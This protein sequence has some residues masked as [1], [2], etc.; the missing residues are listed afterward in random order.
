MLKFAA[1]CLVSLT[2][3]STAVAQ[4]EQ[5]TYRDA[6]VMYRVVS[7]QTVRARRVVFRSVTSEMKAALW[8]VHV[9]HFLD[10]HLELSLVQRNVV[11]QFLTLI[12]AELYQPRPD[13]PEWEA[14][15]G[16]PFARMEQSASA[17]LSPELYREAFA[18][19]GPLPDP[20]SDSDAQIVSTAAMLRRS[21]STLQP[22]YC[23]GCYAPDCECN[24]GDNWCF[25]GQS[26]FGDNCKSDSWGCGTVWQKICNGMCR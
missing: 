15:I 8:R 24:L 26:C 13:D 11:T 2:L 12:T 20:D 14:Q 5:A 4:G 18:V 3:T 17:V 21:P 16:V 22:D 23:V 7:A 1:I 10:S 6:E 25:W 9:R 19:L